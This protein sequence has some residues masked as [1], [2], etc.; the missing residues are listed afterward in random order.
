M[1]FFPPP[2]PV[3]AFANGTY[4]SSSDLFSGY[5]ELL[6]YLELLPLYNAFNLGGPGTN[7][8]GG[9]SP[10]DPRN[11]TGYQVRAT[12]FLCPSDWYG[13]DIT[14][15][16]N[17]Y[18]FNL[19]SSNPTGPYHGGLPIGAFDA[20]APARPADFRDGMSQTVGFSERSL[21]SQ[22]QVNFDRGR[23]FWGAGVLGLFQIEDDDDVL[24]VCRSLSGNPGS[25]LTNLGQTWTMGGNIYVWYNHVA[26]PNDLGSDCETGDL[27]TQQPRYCEYC[28]LGARSLHPGG[29]NCLSMDGSVHFVKNAINL[30]VWRALGTRSGG[31]AIELGW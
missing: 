25:Y 24:K 2:M 18:R 23:D 22:S 14:N 12:Q 29:V 28:S 15:G 1:Q 5:Y 20:T 3:R 7:Q 26:P 31:E 21:G 8:P 19:G 30:R 27:N 11:S 6:P 4:F 13:A 9:I 17:S 10:V 16:A